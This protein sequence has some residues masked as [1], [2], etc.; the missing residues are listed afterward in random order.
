MLFVHGDGSAYPLG[1]AE[2]GE[3]F[4]AC[5]CDGWEVEVV[6]MWL[7]DGLADEVDAGVVE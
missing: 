3:C 6:E 7:R 2:R 4:G 1:E 5:F